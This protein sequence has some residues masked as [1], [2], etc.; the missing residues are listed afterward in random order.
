[1][2]IKYLGTAA[3][4]GWPAVFCGCDA[5]R[6]AR[7]LGGKNIRTRSQ[8]IIDDILLVDL[9]AETLYHSLKGSIELGSIKTLLITHSHEDHFYPQE[10]LYRGSPYA[11][12][13]KT[14]VLTVYGNETVE[15]LYAAVMNTADSPDL[16]KNIQ[17]KKVIPYRPFQTAEGYQ[18]TALRARHAPKEECLLYLIEKDGKCLFY[19]NDSGDYPQ[20]TWDYLKGRH[21]DFVGLDCTCML[22]AEGTNHMGL[23]DNIKA[24]QRLEMIGCTGAE[25]QYVITHFSHNGRLLHD[26][27]AREAQKYGMTAAYDGAEFTF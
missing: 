3:A 19:A 23:P 1:M 11:H 4:E 10:L 13:L 17:F 18:V 21:I 8:A 26:E 14:S 20:E 6:R 24:K 27:I 12:D 9:P 16:M 5:C 2:K 15:K 25:T 22:D 7:A